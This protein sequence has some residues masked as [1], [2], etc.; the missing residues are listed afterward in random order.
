[1]NILTKN[2]EGKLD[3]VET[4]L[5]VED[6]GFTSVGIARHLASPGVIFQYRTYLKQQEMMLGNYIECFEKNT[7]IRVH[8]TGDEVW[9]ED[10]T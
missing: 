3:Q 1:M 7:G 6:H 8:K 9:L 5:G 4:F 10:L 2:A